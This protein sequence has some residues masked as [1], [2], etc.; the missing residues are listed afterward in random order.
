MPSRVL[1]KVTSVAQACCRRRT[2][3]MAPA[4]EL[5]RQRQPHRALQRYSV[6]LQPLDW[7]EARFATPRSPTGRTAPRPSAAD[8]AIRISGRRQSPAVA[9]KPWL[10]DV[11]LGVRDI[12]GTGLFSSDISSPTSATTISISAPALPGVTWAI[13]ATS[14]TRWAMSVIASIQG[15]RS[16]APVT[17]TQVR[18]FA[19]SLRFS[20]V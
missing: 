8:R 2:A 7:L 5:K 3:R 4:G 11:A 16:K 10:P 17:S 6:S 12:G 13:A 18:T 19:A 15:L 20:A 1:L 14:T 9:G